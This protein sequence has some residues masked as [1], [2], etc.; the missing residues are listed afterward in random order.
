MNKDDK[1]FFGLALK[2]EYKNNKEMILCNA[3]KITI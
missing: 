2:C 3:I 1:M